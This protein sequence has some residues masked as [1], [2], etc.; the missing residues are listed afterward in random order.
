MS[1]FGGRTTAA[2]AKPTIA[3]SGGFLVPSASVKASV[4]ERRD[5]ENDAQLNKTSHKRAKREYMPTDVPSKHAGEPREGEGESAPFLGSEVVEERQDG[6]GNAF[7]DLDERP[8]HG[9]RERE[10]DEGE[11]AKQAG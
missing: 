8:A 2:P 7:G 4:D 11:I 3:L 10:R 5:E 9:D 1:P 6:F